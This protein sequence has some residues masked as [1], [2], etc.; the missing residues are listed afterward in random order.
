MGST[1]TV[2]L[3]SE[4]PAEVFCASSLSQVDKMKT[5][6]LVVLLAVAVTAAV[7]GNEEPEVV[8]VPD[9]AEDPVLAAIANRRNLNVGSPGNSARIYNQQI[10]VNGVANQVT[11][12]NI[13]STATVALN[14]EEPAEVF[15]TSSLSQVDKMKILVLVVLLAAAV[16]AAV[17]GNEE[18]EVVILRDDV[19]EDPVLATIANRRNLN[20][21]S[22]GNSARIYNTQHRMNGA[23]NQVMM[24]TLVLVVLLA[25]AV[26][27]AVV[28]NE[29][30][31]VVM[32]PDVVEDPVLAAIANR[33]NLNVGSPGNS[34]RIYNQQIRRKTEKMKNVL[35]V[36]LIAT[37]SAAVIS[38]PDVVEVPDVDNIAD[39]EVNAIREVFVTDV[40]ELTEVEEPATTAAD[41]RQELNLGNLTSADRLVIEREYMET[42]T[43]DIFKIR[44]I[45]SDQELWKPSP[46]KVDKMKSLVL[47]VLLAAAATAAVL[48]NNLY[49]VVE[50]PDGGQLVEIHYDT[51]EQELTGITD[52]RNL[53]V[54]T[55]SG[56]VSID[57]EVRANG[58]PNRITVDSVVAR[59]TTGLSSPG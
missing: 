50:L 35:I 44:F 52:R 53:A 27:A 9:V 17:V 34:A 58:I 28:G 3:N 39:E 38:E 14:S 43:P 56:T 42:G 32:V 2:A 1:A 37:A 6:V 55:I 48:D 45:I 46:N 29:E 15:C 5:L 36:F 47:V 25:A 24:K 23:A 22:P 8:M 12:R 40:V 41:T 54:G 33:R 16:T 20:V 19:V 10:R 49:E 59:E 30:P 18:P 57:R 21:G 7:V 11:V 4:E 13:Q 31:E 26:T 51:D